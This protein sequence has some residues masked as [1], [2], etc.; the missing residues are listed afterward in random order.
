MLI[1]MSSNLLKCS[2]RAFSTLGTHLISRNSGILRQDV[3]SVKSVTF[4]TVKKVYNLSFRYPEK[5]PITQITKRFYAK[6]PGNLSFEVDGNVAKDVIVFT[7]SNTRFFRMLSI[8]GIVQFFFWAHMAVFA[9][10]GSGLETRSYD[11]PSSFSNMVL[12]FQNQ[13]KY[14][15]AIACI[16]LGKLS[17][18]INYVW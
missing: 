4:Q 7:Y 9:Y 5:Q 10:S 3:S 16:A 18:V 11:G 8:F 14:R 2:K 13:N 1:C 17:K 12:N 6:K 15:I